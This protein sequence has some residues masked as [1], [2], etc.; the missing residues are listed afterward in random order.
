MTEKANP[1]YNMSKEEILYQLL[2]KEYDFYLNIYEITKEENEKLRQR[3]PMNEISS[4]LKRKRS[5]LNSIA[6]VETAMQ[7]LKNYWQSNKSNKDQ[8]SLKIREEL[9]N[10]DKLL[11]RILE[12]DLVSQRILESYLSSLSTEQLLTKPSISPTTQK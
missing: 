5:L 8:I 2:R 4:L 10:L 6:E 11:N 9:A 7:P 3:N 1:I 12:L